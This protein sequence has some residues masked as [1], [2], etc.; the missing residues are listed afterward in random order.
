MASK[1]RNMFYDNKKQEKTEIGVAWLIIPLEIRWTL[2]PG[3]V[4]TS[5]RLLLLS[6]AIPFLVSCLFLVVLPESPKYLMTRGMDQETIRALGQAFSMNTG[7][8]RADYPVKEVCLD[9]GD[10]L[11]EDTG[12][13]P[14]GFLRAMWNQTRLLFTPPLLLYTALCCVIHVGVIGSYNMLMLWF[15]ETVNEMS[16][17]WA[18]H[19]EYGVTLCQVLGSGNSSVIEAG[20]QTDIEIA[21]WH[22]RTQAAQP[23]ENGTIFTYNTVVDCVAEVNTKVFM[24]N[25]AVGIVQVA[26]FLFTNPIIDILGKRIEAGPLLHEEIAR[27]KSYKS[28]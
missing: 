22:N 19:P 9:S 11:A 3:M 1:R 8:D 27:P 6:N 15:P 14:F 21:F 17:Y 28:A 12:D 25:I 24:S 20:G 2:W 13:T 10:V 26:V 4:F 18:D 23:L 16:L 5:W 7:R